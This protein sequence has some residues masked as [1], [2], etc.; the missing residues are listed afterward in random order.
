MLSEFTTKERSNLIK[1]SVGIMLYKFALE[2]MNACLNGI[3]LNRLPVFNEGIQPG[4][5]WA[6]MQGLNLFFQCFGS[7]IVGPLVRRFNTKSV[8]SL[9]TL[10]FAIIATSVPISE[11]ISG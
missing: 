10:L 8:L 5:T 11:G 4:I 2:S 1:Y 3:V 7:L 9:T 6:N